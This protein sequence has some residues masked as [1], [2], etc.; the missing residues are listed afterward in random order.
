MDLDQNITEKFLS[1]TCAAFD[2]LH[3]LRDQIYARIPSST[4]SNAAELP[5]PLD[6][7]PHSMQDLSSVR[8]CVT[9]TYTDDGLVYL[10]DEDCPV[11]ANLVP[12]E[13]L[14]PLSGKPDCAELFQGIR[15]DLYADAKSMIDAQKNNIYFDLTND[16][17]ECLRTNGTYIKATGL[18]FFGD[19]LTVAGTDVN[20]A[21]DSCP[22]DE[23]FLED[24]CGLLISHLG[25]LE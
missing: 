23:I 3:A 13:C 14:A 17:L 15:Q 11:C 1:D 19:V 5:M 6:V 4:D 20:G 9:H 16:S 8:I 25:E 22:A 10:L 7:F 12:I 21:A 18:Y 2:T 24:F